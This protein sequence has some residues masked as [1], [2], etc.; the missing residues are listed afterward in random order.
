MAGLTATGFEIKTT[1][2]LADEMSD[3]VKSQLGNVNTQADSI[4]G[5]LLGVVAARLGSLW[6]LGESIY[7]ALDPDDATGD[8][9]DGVC[10]F[11]G[12]IREDAAPSTLVAAVD[13]DAGTT[14]PAG[15]RA[16]VEDASSRI[17]ETDAEVSSTT[18]R[19]WHT[20]AMTSIE[21][22]PTVAEEA[23]LN[24][25]DTPVSGWNA[26]TNEPVGA[27]RWTAV[28]PFSLTDGM[29][30]D[31]DINFGG[32]Q[33]ATFNT[34]DFVD[35]NNAL[36]DEVALVINTD[37]SDQVSSDDGGR[38]KIVAD[39]LGSAAR[40]RISGG[41]ALAA[42]GLTSAD[43]Y[44]V[45]G[46]EAELGQLEED[47]ATLRARRGA[48]LERQ[49][50]S[51]GDTLRARL[52][53]IDGMLDVSVYQ[54]RT[55][56]TD[57]GGLPPKS[58]RAVVLG[59]A[60]DD[61]EI[62]QT[63]FDNSPLGIES[64][65]SETVTIYDSQGTA[66]PIYWDVAT[67]IPLYVEATISAIAASYAGDDVV[68]AAVAAYVT[69]LLMGDDVIAEAAKGRL[70]QAGV[71]DITAFLID[72]VD[73]PVAATNIAVGLDEVATLDVADIDLT[74]NYVTPS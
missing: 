13:L 69:A 1:S 70:F 14:L 5:I 46:T 47:D 51:T 11:T 23:T 31:I 74:T 48:E 33:T 40:I 61:D 28:E 63:I 22:G 60:L 54:N 2:E 57:G 3:D 59:D 50:T 56:V 37:V 25:I 9:L 24:Q 8:P 35:I 7:R 71:Y 4:L 34:G 30:L 18:I 62:A 66:V 10:E 36:A 29:T 17:F 39:A 6:E 32:V 53:E 15:S 42:L 16:S 21:D 58:F 38:A 44:G 55:D 67:A 43:V 12:T 19:Q 27:T 72:D 26:V 41:T 20:V 68:K 65:G 52:L 49:G 64:Y 73:P 45:D